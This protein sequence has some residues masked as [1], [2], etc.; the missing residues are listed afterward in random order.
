MT[1]LLSLDLLDTRLKPLCNA[2][3]GSAQV[4]GA[5]IA[6]VAGDKGYHYAYGVKSIA[7]GEQVTAQTGF[8]IGSCSK[9][10][11]SA[12]VASLVAE[13]LATWDDRIA[14]YVPEFQLYDPAI[15]QQVTLRDLSGNR[16][17]LPRE[18]LA[19]MG[20]DPTLPSSHAF[21]SLRYTQPSHPFRD[22]FTYVNPGHTANAVAAGRITGR[23]YLATLRE[24]ILSP[25]GMNGTS[26]GV[27]ARDELSDQAS[28][29]TLIEG[30]VVG[31]DTVFTDHYLGSGGMV[32]PG[33]DAL[34][35]LRLQLNAGT[36]DHQQIVARDALLET[37]MAHSAARPGKDLVSLIYPGAHLGSYA[38]GWAVSDFEGHP[39]VCHSGSD[40]GV[41]AMTLLL[42][43]AGIGIAVYCNLATGNTVSTAYALAATLL[44]LG[45]RD[46][47]AYFAAMAPAPEA[48]TSTERSPA[49]SDP[50][51]YLGI[52]RHPA[53]GPLVIERSGN[54]LQG[55]LTNG[56]RM[57]FTLVPED[58]HRFEFR[59]SQHEWQASASRLKIGL[60]FTVIGGLAEKV[61]VV[62][63]PC[64]GRIFDR[65]EETP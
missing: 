32:V 36:V 14:K 53:D 34:Q 49:L 29:H 18:G 61:E 35:W 27:A 9:S 10:F 16:L 58:E 56:Y 37:H 20:F 52:Y 5:S 40:L 13:G 62:G 33:I 22:R 45:P 55:N 57:A 50:G 31:I 23:G 54:N 43:K 3:L 7:T 6:V 25:L 2:Y 1:S 60:V 4:P 59:F 44:G 42:P 26:G 47:D 64:N 46:W 8:N 28:W 41:T 30:D 19:E 17:G 12:T 65:V 39:L 51:P 63:G 48:P 15:T 38:L 24:R 11:V 21:E